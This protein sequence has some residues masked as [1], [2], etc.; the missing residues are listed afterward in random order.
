MA[1]GLFSAEPI[2]LLSPQILKIDRS[3]PIVS[4]NEQTPNR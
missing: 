4:E 1:D 3:M 2:T